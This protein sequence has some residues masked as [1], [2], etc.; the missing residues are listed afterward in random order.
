VQKPDHVIEQISR[1]CV[2]GQGF[3]KDDAS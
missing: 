3:C 2:R 1:T